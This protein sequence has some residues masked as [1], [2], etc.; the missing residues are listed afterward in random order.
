MSTPLLSTPM[1]DHV[2]VC[3]PTYR[4]NRMLERLIRSL[5]DQETAALFEISLVVVDNEPTGPARELVTRLSDKLGLDITYGIETQHTIPAVRNHALRLARGNYIG[6]IDD[7]EFAPS[8]WLLTLYRGIRTFDVDGVIGPALPFFEQRPPNWLLKAGLCDPP[9]HRTGTLLKWQH[10]FTNNNLVKRTVFDEHGL[11]FDERF[12]T[13]GSDQDFFRRAMALGYRFVAVQEAP[14]YE[15]VPP[16]RWTRRYWLK[17]ALVNGFNASRYAATGMNWTL[18]RALALK[19]MIAAPAY[20]MAT[21]IS[22]CFGQH[23]LIQCLEKAA[24][25]VSR[26]CATF[27]VELWSRRDF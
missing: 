7:D 2:S 21:P 14:V 10:C 15:V 17:R 8:N 13:G 16:V 1:I 23:R 11:G 20:A 22:V 18:R 9:L 24:Y 6:I 19:S 26:A 3:I 27:G 25:H 5:A 4:R 12:K